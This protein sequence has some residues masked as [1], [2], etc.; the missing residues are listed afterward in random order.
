MN[1]D[2]TDTS[3]PVDPRRL[4]PTTIFTLLSEDRR[5]H[6]MRY[7]A[8]R[9]GAVPIGDVAE[10]IALCEDDSTG[11]RV[12]RVVTGLYHVHVP[13]LREAGVVR[14]D[15]ERETIERLAAADQLLPYLDLVAGADCR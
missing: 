8:R 7:L 2:T 5:R 15:P 14:Y 3:T 1:T 13:L 4:S 12:E 11:H 10:Q 6:T 9:V